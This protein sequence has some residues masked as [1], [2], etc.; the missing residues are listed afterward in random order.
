MQASLV[1]VNEALGMYSRVCGNANV[2]KN[3]K[4]DIHRSIQLLLG[5]LD[6]D[7]VFL[8]QR[9]GWCFGL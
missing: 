4:Y 3:V 7:I 1:V 8:M 9:N 6:E 2:V 5:I